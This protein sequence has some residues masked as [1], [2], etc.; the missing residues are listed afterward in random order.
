VIGVMVE[1]WVVQM[2]VVDVKYTWGKTRIEVEPIEGSGR[3]F[4]ELSRVQRDRH[5]DGWAMVEG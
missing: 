2:R 3:Q 1:S 5:P 4:V